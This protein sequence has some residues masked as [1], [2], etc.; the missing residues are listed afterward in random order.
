MLEAVKRTYDTIINN[1]QLIFGIH[2]NNGQHNV[3]QRFLPYRPVE[4]VVCMDQ[5]TRW[6]QTVLMVRL[7][8]L[9]PRKG[10]RE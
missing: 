8:Q 3:D 4:W 5:N 1:Q 6:H 9:M 2:M 10:S 7:N